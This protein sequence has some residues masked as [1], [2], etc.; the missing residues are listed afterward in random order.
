MNIF[1][2]IYIF[3]VLL[4]IV[5][6]QSMAKES[7]TKYNVE[8]D[9]VV[10]ITYAARFSD[11]IHTDKKITISIDTGRELVRR[12][13]G[14]DYEFKLSPNMD[15]QRLMTLKDK[16]TYCHSGL[17]KTPERAAIGYFSQPLYLYPSVKLYFSTDK[18]IPEDL[19]DEHGE[20]ISLKALFEYMPN[21]KLA[22]VDKFSYGTFLDRKIAELDKK[23]LNIRSGIDQYTST[24]LM[25]FKHRIDFAIFYPASYLR[26][27]RK[28]PDFPPLQSL[29]IKGAEPYVLGHVMCS[30]TQLGKKMINIVD[31]ILDKMYQEE[32]F[33]NMHTSHLHEE[34]I[35]RF[36][37]NF[38]KV[39][40][41][42]NF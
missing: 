25:S 5:N 37:K 19:I 10:W 41:E 29:N 26:M 38:Q 9:S 42:R 32:T 8:K 14:I 13:K 7:L 20:L 22:V 2:K 40:I 35:P 3:V 4:M 17:I 31:K 11:N 24:I 12:I 23:N 28:Y 1:N 21:K 6:C 15:I 39:F 16:I 27:R 18:K 30:K 36:N 33:Y 34:D